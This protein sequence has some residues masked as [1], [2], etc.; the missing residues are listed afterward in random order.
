MTL[1]SVGV[2]HGL[3]QLRRARASRR[4]PVC[5]AVVVESKIR[6]HGGKRGP[7]YE[8]VVRYQYSYGGA[9]YE[10]RRIMFSGYGFR[11]TQEDVARFLEPV[12]KGASIGVHVCPRDPRLSVILP[13]V[14]RNLLLL[15]FCASFLLLM[16]G[17]GLLGWWDQPAAIE[18]PT[19]VESIRRCGGT[20]PG[21]E[22]HHFPAQS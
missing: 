18:R 4:W 7:S 13:G 12:P 6:G 1:G 14:D 2:V 22:P 3:V 11:S 17:G 5:E 19:S 10:G 16:G 9:T 8:P 15:L 20:C 21:I